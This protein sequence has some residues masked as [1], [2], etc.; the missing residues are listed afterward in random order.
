MIATDAIEQLRE[1]GYLVDRWTVDVVG[2]DDQTRI[3]VRFPHGTDRERDIVVVSVSSPPLT[4]DDA[5][6][7]AALIADGTFS[8]D[9]WARTALDLAEGRA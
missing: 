4:P 8:I 3:E 5:E 2:G 7:T 6:I 9:R 1:L